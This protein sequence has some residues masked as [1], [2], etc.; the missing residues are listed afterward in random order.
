MKNLFDLAHS[1][2]RK[3]VTSRELVQHCLHNIEAQ[4]GEGHNTFLSVYKERALDEA[5]ACDA[6]RRASINLSPFSG[7]PISIKDLFDVAGQT[8]TAGSHVLDE[9]RPAQHDAP[10]ISKL[11]QAGFIIIGKTNM[12]EFAYSGLGINSHYGTPASPYD[13]QTRCIPGGSSSGAAVSVSDE[14]AAAAIGTDT[15]GSTRIP[16]ALCG[17][18][19]FK[20]TA[21]RI[22]TEGSV[23][24]SPSLD[25]I[26]PIA[27]SVSCCALL[28]SLIHI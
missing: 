18:V 21:E 17:L 24:L 9:Q 6:A 13:R 7:I 1:L 15:G 11:R 23:P 16:A 28:L 25:S 3:K 27:N 20:P 10:V 5:D 8:T 22:S 12:T 2:E 26:G 19:G 4:G 14:M